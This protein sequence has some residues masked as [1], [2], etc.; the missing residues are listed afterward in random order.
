M[1]EALPAATHN[2]IVEHVFG[3]TVE[4]FVFNVT[5][6][7]GL[8]SSGGHAIKDWVGIASNLLSYA[9]MEE[10]YGNVRPGDAAAA[11]Q[12]IVS[13]IDKQIKKQTADAAIR[14]TAFT[15][16]GISVLADGGTA[17]MAALGALESIAI[18]LNMLVDLVIDARQ[19][20]A[21][22]KLITEGKI[23]I[24]L[25]NTCPL[26]GCYYV[27]IQDHSTIMNFDIANM[28]R[29]NWQQE[30]ERLRYAL[31]PVIRKATE[32]IDASRI[33]IPGMEF[34]KGVYQSTFLQ[35]IK[36]AYN[37]W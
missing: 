33:E 24:E 26:L 36:L 7:F 1:G 2:A 15:A 30:A 12:A 34:A 25:F 9:K 22:N 17:T 31:D 29:D 21:G 13:I 6:V 5:P 23:D 16:K 27:A 18:L 20:I 10:Q 4:Q 19:M 28:G 3:A 37:S 11:L 14:T 35:K 8:I 32:L